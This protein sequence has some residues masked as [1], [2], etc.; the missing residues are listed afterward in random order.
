MNIFTHIHVEKYRAVVTGFLLVF[1]FH[2]ASDLFVVFWQAILS[3][4]LLV[5]AV[6][7]AR[8]TAHH[9]HAGHHH[10]GDSPLDVVAVSVLLLANVLHPAVDGFSLYETFQLGGIAA[11]IV[12]AGSVLLHEIFRQSALITVFSAM[13]ISWFWVVTTALLGMGGGMLAGILGTTFLHQY[14][15]VVEMATLFAYGFIIAEF[16][17][18]HPHSQIKKPWIFLLGGIVLGIVI[19]VLSVT[20]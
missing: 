20:H 14:E 13:Q 11:G 4:L 19:T 6:L 10:P 9:F 2:I 1:A 12:Y 8:A 15:V 18:A 16:Y 5:G 17:F 7:L 3:G